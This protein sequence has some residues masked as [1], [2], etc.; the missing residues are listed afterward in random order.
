[1]LA[2]KGKV[3]KKNFNWNNENTLVMKFV[4]LIGSNN[5]LKKKGKLREHSFKFNF[6]YDKRDKSLFYLSSYPMAKLTKT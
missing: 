2:K 6:R 4:D 3:I 1:M 5:S